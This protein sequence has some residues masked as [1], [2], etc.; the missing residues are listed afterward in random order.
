MTKVQN[1]MDSTT[2]TLSGQYNT[3]SAVIKAEL[4]KLKERNEQQ[5][6]EM[7]ALQGTMKTDVAALSDQYSTGTAVIRDELEKLMQ[8]QESE[9]AALQAQIK[10]EMLAV[11][12][13]KIDSTTAA[14]SDQNKIGTTAIEEKMDK[15]MHLMFGLAFGIGIFLP[16]LLSF[17][18]QIER[19]MN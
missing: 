4:E 8:Q 12:L 19:Q 17:F 2:T 3:G 11:L 9:I 18:W 7:V 5:D 14:L 16:F 15:L 1:K 6:S 13:D 10:L